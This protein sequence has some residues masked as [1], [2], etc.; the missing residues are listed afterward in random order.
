MRAGVPER[1]WEVFRAMRQQVIVPEVVTYN[2]L[3]GMCGKGKQT[4]QA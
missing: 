4:E 2:A 3:V 1:A